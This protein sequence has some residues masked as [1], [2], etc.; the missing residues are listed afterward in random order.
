MTKAGMVSVTV[1]P[2]R[3]KIFMNYRNPMGIVFA[4]NL[5]L[6]DLEFPLLFPAYL[7]HL[8]SDEAGPLT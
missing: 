1:F 4:Y 2:I 8:N 3:G 5:F 7:Y 6:K